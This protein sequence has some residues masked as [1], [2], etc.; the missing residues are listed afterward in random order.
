MTT[1]LICTRA[2]IVSLS[3][4]VEFGQVKLEKWSWIIKKVYCD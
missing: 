2:D 1:V 3:N 4:I